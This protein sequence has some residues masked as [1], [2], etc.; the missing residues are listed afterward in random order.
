[1]Y[2]LDRGVVYVNLDRGTARVLAE[3]SHC[4]K[5]WARRQALAAKIAEAKIAKAVKSCLSVLSV[6]VSIRLRRRLRDYR[7]E[8]A[9]LWM[10]YTRVRSE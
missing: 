9:S 2:G 7:R 3:D 6:F 10:V 1:M 4:A 8:N 5:Q